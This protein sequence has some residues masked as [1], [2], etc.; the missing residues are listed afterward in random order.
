MIIL[1]RWFL[2]KGSISRSTL[3]QL[4]LVYMSLASDIV[5]MLSLLSEVQLQDSMPM[6]YATLTVF[7]WSL[8][9]FSLNLVVT[10]GRSFQGV[11]TEDIDDDMSYNTFGQSQFS[12]KY[13]I[14]SKNKA[15]S[16]FFFFFDCSKFDFLNNEIWSILVTLVFQDGPFL[17][18]RLAAVINFNVRTFSTMFY[19]CKNAIILFLQIYR[20]VA[21]YNESE[22]KDVI[23]DLGNNFSGYSFIEEKP[24][25]RKSLFISANPKQSRL[26]TNLR[27]I[28]D[29]SNKFICKCECHSKLINNNVP[30]VNESSTQIR[31]ENES[32]QD[33]I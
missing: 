29:N 27:Y 12:N 32:S 23:P 13:S 6:I 24:M 21:I 11:V 19:T 28:D 10:R 1:G 2:P 5:D 18:I 8:F 9:Q 22:E 26:V 31:T 30:V 14:E 20:L 25:N 7:S 3:S 17:A 15:W 33:K 4:L 16:K